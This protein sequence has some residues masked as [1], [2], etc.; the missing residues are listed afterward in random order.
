MN[1]GD[2]F[3]ATTFG[4]VRYACGGGARDG[5]WLVHCEPHVSTRLKRVFPRAP[6]RASTAIPISNTPENAR[7]LEWFL[8][9][10]PMEMTRDDAGRLANASRAHVELERRVSDLLAHRAALP[11][12]EMAL[13]PRDYQRE[14][15]QM[16][17][18]V[19]G[20]LLADDLGLGKTVTSLCAMAQGENLPALVVA[21]V[22]LLTQWRDELHRFLPNLRVHIINSGRPYPLTKQPRQR[23]PDLW[24][25]MPDVLIINPHK[26]DGWAETL[27][28]LVRYVVNDE[29]QW[30][31]TGSSIAQRAFDL[32]VRKADPLVLG[33]SATPI[34]NLGGEFWNVVDSLRPG[35]LGSHEEFIREWCTAGSDGKPRLSDAKEFGQY[36]RRA[37]IMLR[38][39]REDVGRELP[40]LQKIIHHVE[41]DDAPLSEIKSKAAALARVIVSANEGYRG[42]QMEAA[43]KFESLMRQ[44]T[45][46]AKAQHVAA[47]VRMLVECGEQVVLFG[48]HHAVYAIWME[49]LAEFAPGLYTG[50]QTTA[51]KD[52]AKAEF[53]AGRSKVII[54]SLRSGAGLDGLQMVCKVAVVGELDW[55]PGV[56]EQCIGRVYRDGQPDPVQAYFL[57]TDEGSDPIITDVL[58][59][60][61]QQIEHVR[62]PDMSVA[63]RVDTGGNAIRQ[64]A[65]R[66]L[67][68]V[69]GPSAET[70]PFDTLVDLFTQ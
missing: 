66:Y 2:L 56:H 17:T 28:Q 43:G 29:C 49:A 10:Y 64:L 22:H 24:S 9:R 23:R 65:A 15:F 53:I 25:T 37:G 63:E 47:F 68:Q 62:N 55:S 14:A 41:A 34:Y 12:V 3:T 30:M 16:L 48:W 19:R 35:A 40:P 1:G 70:V 69:G 7:E 67:A 58:G 32:I 31:R 61:R 44:A 51:Q 46:V 45:G 36:L 33:L 27:A 39:T 38:R 20:L 5:T 60:K 21:P 50:E 54:V 18:S 6:V 42:E 13:P 8:Q 57:V 26:L 11:D 59:L 4:V 52:H